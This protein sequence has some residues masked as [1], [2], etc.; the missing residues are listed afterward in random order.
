MKPLEVG[1]C[2]SEEQL[3]ERKNK[4]KYEYVFSY[5]DDIC[6]ND[7]QLSP[8]DAKLLNKYYK[9]QDEEKF[10]ALFND[11]FSD[12]HFVIRSIYDWSGPGVGW[13][14]AEIKTREL[15]IKDFISY[16][17]SDSRYIDDVEVLEVIEPED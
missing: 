14:S 11:Y 10:I 2:Y 15:T 6:W 12:L 8:E 13:P 4:D 9:A 16:M 1:E 7:S 17:N 3:E 5:C